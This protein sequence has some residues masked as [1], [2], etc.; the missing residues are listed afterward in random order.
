MDLLFNVYTLIDSYI[1]IP[2]PFT[3]ITLAFG[4]AIFRDQIKLSLSLKFI[5]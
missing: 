1:V 3:I 5:Q 4:K 2:L